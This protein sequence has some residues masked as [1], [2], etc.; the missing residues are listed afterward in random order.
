M[1]SAYRENCS[2]Y[3]VDGWTY[4]LEPSTPPFDSYFYGILVARREGFKPIYC[5]L[6]KGREGYELV[7]FRQAFLTVKDHIMYF[8]EV[9]N[10]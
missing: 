3:A 2:R 5:G 6:L 10:G 8:A 9:S 1:D 7:G 4:D